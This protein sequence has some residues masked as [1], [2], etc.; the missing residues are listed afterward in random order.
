MHLQTF[1]EKSKLKQIQ[2]TLNSMWRSHF[3][4]RKKHDIG[5]I[6][7]V[8]HGLSC[9]RNEKGDGK[10]WLQKCFQTTSTIYLN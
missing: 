9:N 3:R 1:N 7:T 6:C 4:N 5:A 8:K 10:C 2:I